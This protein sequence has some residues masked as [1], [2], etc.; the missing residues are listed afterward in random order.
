MSIIVIG[1]AFVDIK[2]FPIGK[3][4]PDGRNAGRIEYVHGGV[5][6]NVAED[7]ANAGMSAAYLGI[8]D[9]SPL[10]DAVRRRLADRGVD[11]SRLLTVPDGMGTWLAVFNEKGDVAGSVSKRP[12]MLPVAD[13]LSEEGNEIFSDADSAVLEFD[14]DEE[15]VSKTLELGKKHRVPVIG[16]VSN[17]SLALERREYLSGLACF[18]CNNQEAG[19]LFETDCSSRTPE[20]MLKLLITEREKQK[21]PAMIVTLGEKGAVFASAH[22]EAGLVPARKVEVIDTTGAGDAFCAGVACGLTR[23]LS[24]SGAAE[25]GAAFAASVIGS[26]ENVCPVMKEVFR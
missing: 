21:I 12:D 7:I 18:I 19:L 3:Y 6:R 20:E 13:L 4:I 26:K 2:G 23:K 25:I 10:G 17:M 11:T 8:V 24:L 22:G 1:A 5:A 14:L 9:D 15:I 16:L